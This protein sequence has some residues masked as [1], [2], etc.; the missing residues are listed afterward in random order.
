MNSV[1]GRDLSADFP[2]SDRIYLNSAS[3]SLMP[4]QSIAA[5]GEFLVS[6]NS[7]GPDSQ[8]AASL[9]AETLQSARRAVAG[10]I[11][12][13]PDEV[14]FTQSTTDGI[15]LVANGLA[16]DAGSNMV[17]RGMSHEHHA[18]LL[19]WLRLEDRRK[20]SIR[21]LPVDGN[22]GLFSLKDLESSLDGR[23][24]L[25]ALSHALYNTGA[26]L[27]LEEVGGILRGRREAGGPAV[28]FFVDAAQTV[29]Q[30]DGVD[31]SKLGCDFMS[32]NGSKWLCGPMGTG[33]FYCSRDSAGMLEPAAIGG[34]SAAIGGGGGGAGLVL[35]DPPDRFQAGFR[36]YVGMAGLVSSVNYLVG[37]GLGNIRERN[38]RLSALLREEL[39]GIP[40]IVLYGPEDPDGRASIVSFNVRGIDPQKAVEAL[41]RREKIVLAVREIVDER[42]IRASPHFFNTESD[43]LLAADAI[44]RLPQL[45]P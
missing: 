31:V 27:P 18:N 6:Y 1:L 39:S 33:I 9:V 30:L 19:A 22:D 23:T 5:M 2:E 38:K 26:I 16:L 43:V 4:S 11:S 13:R 36:N 35:K 45:L 37:I 12:C 8:R 10:L 20:I 32:F 41:E 34:E 25:V 40:G 15:N 24:R 14:V 17:I 3:V 7:A 42:I 29:G 28:P 21:S 44:K